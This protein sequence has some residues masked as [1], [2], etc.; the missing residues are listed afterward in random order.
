MQEQNYKKHVRLHPPFHFIGFPL[1]LITVIGSIIC[2]FTTFSWIS[3]ILLVSSVTLFINFFLT[4]TYSTKLQ[5]RIVR[6][7]ENFRHYTLTGVPLNAKLTLSQIITLRFASD[8]EFPALCAKT[9]NENLKPD[10]IKKTI[11]NWKSDFM[12]V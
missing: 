2:L 8:E 1:V 4:R 3:I 11:K 6:L 9:V 12:R 5:D 7:E 10:E